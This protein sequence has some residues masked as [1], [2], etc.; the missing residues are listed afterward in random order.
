MKSLNHYEIFEISSDASIQEIK[1][2]FKRMTMRYSNE[3]HP[4]EF[5]NMK[6]IYEELTNV[7]R[8]NKYDE[9]LRLGES[10]LSQLEYLER[11][12]ERDYSGLEWSQ[13]TAL[14]H[15]L[16]DS[17]RV[18]NLLLEGALLL[19]QTDKGLDYADRLNRHKQLTHQN[20][21]FWVY[22]LRKN[23][24]YDKAI[25]ELKIVIYE[26][27]EKNLE[28]LTLYGE[29]LMI[30]NRRSDA[31]NR[32]EKWI[33]QH[34][35]RRIL[36][37]KSW[38]E[39]V[40]FWGQREQLKTVMSW[41]E[42]RFT[43]EEQQHV[44][45]YVNQSFE[46]AIEFQRFDSAYILLEECKQ[47]IDHGLNQEGI[48]SLIEFGGVMEELEMA[49]ESNTMPWELLQPVYEYLEYMKETTDQNL[50]N[51]HCS[52]T[53]LKEWLS[54]KNEHKGWI[55]K[56]CLLFPKSYAF[57]ESEFDKVFDVFLRGTR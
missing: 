40:L 17:D 26:E 6:E 34:S 16:L 15:H 5:L 33:I 45:T 19:N 12:L 13:F 25:K 11:T 3:T 36:I 27:E 55:A 4:E 1:Q 29:L 9:G 57:L 28:T 2:A 51:V 53:Y 14:E 52:F 18:A 49:A 23:R 37:W 20:R 10:I 24:E 38:L 56:F 30:S 44:K 47:W 42:N 46:K 39:A 32:Y 43:G 54:E 7:E 50:E 21:I 41:V 22:L 48:Q 8:R 31:M 35:D